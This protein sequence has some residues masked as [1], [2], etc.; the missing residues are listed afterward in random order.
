[1]KKLI[2]I[3]LT[4]ALCI[5]TLAGCGTA[6]STSSKLSLGG[7]TSVEKVIQAMMEAYMAENED[8]KITYAPTGSSTGIQGVNDGTLDIGLSSRSLKAEE[9]ATLTETVFALDGI[10]V[11]VNS[12]N[13][14]TDLSIETLA[15]IYKGEVTNWKDVGGSDSEIVVIGRDAAS[16]TR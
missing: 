6:A 1:M 16:G 8:I 4:L 15:K 2:A 13:A 3:T 7:S 14:V 9:K 12:K 10:A 5:G 11:I